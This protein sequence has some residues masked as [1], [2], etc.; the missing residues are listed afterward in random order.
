MNSI[1]LEPVT[2]SF[3]RICF[4]LAVTYLRTAFQNG[5]VLETVPC[6]RYGVAEPNFRLP[7][8]ATGREALQ[9]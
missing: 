7:R 8:N 9:R 6:H 1:R 5:R 3:N 2:Q 4:F